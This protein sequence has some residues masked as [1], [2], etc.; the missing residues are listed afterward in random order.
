MLVFDSL[1]Q[2]RCQTSKLI[3]TRMVKDTNDMNDSATYTK[4][5][6]L[7]QRV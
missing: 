3:F 7:K 1:V 4:K 5:K 2:A 6:C